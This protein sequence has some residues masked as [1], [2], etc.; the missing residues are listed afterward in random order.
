M[1]TTYCYFDGTIAGQMI[2]PKNEIV[3]THPTIIRNV[4]DFSLQELD[5]S[6]DDIAQVL[7]VPAGTLVLFAGIRII[8][9]GTADSTVNFGITGSVVDSWGDGVALDATA[10]T[11]T[12]VMLEPQ[13]VAAADT[14]DIIGTD[15]TTSVDIDAKIEVFAC[16]IKVQN[17]Y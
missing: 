2:P 11:V 6:E 15:D 10:G 12:Q 13:Y 7:Y 14:L 16:C 1:A 3:T 4:V 8:T 5:E 9:A 17:T